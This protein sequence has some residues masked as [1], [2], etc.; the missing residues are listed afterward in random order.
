[1]TEAVLVEMINRERY[2]ELAKLELELVVQGIF[3]GGKP[4]SVQ[5]GV[6]SMTNDY[7]AKLFHHGFSARRL[8]AMLRH[9][10][11]ELRGAQQRMRKLDAMTV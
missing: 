1:M 9:Q 11:N 6:R 5:R 4:E 3:A 8:A 10:L 7:K 2:T